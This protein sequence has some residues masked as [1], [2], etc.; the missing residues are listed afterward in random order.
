MSSELW[1]Q[2][3]GHER[4]NEK[5]DA[6]ERELRALIGRYERAANKPR[7]AYQ[8]LE[9]SF[10]D[11]ATSKMFAQ[12][13]PIPCTS[14]AEAFD[15][16]EKDLADY[17]LIPVENSIFGSVA[18]A[19]DL[20]H[21]RTLWVLAE[22]QMRIRHCLIGERNGKEVYSHPQAL[23]QCR[24]YL[25]NQGLLPI[26]YYDTAGAVRERAGQ[27]LT[28]GS[29]RAAQIYHAQIIEEDIGPAENRTRFFLLAR[30]PQAGTMRGAIIFTLR[31]G[32]S[33][34]TLYQALEALNRYAINL[35]KIESRPAGN[36]SYRFIAEFVHTQQL[37]DALEALKEH[38]AHLRYLGS[39]DILEIE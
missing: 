26:P 7:I 39:Y 2:L 21:E 16:V 6:F 29:A 14:F 5:R 24:T 9:G 15:A 4:I 20:L 8:G 1:N 13:T 19:Y 11:E 10:S 23:G 34:G 31:H 17:A 18:E 28:I 35:T 32:T 36:W 25:N 27:A 3:N 33:P 37:T 38:T 30:E 12:Y 22:A